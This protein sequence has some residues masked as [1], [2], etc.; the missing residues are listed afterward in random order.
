MGKPNQK[1]PPRSCRGSSEGKRNSTP[2]QWEHIHLHA[3]GIDV[4]SEEHYVAVPPGRDPE[5]V[6]VRRF[7]ASPAD[8]HALVSWVERCGIETVAMESTGVYWIALFELLESRDISVCLVNPRH[9][10]SVPGRKTDVLD[11]QWI[12]RLHTYGLLQGSFAPRSRSVCCAA[13]GDNARA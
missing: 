9:L 12:Q 13:T 5:G 3:A 6:D 10:K 8:L 4:G 7:G 11:C 1:R 2:P